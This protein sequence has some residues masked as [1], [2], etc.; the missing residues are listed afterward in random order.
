[1]SNVG[2]VVYRVEE[3][4]LGAGGKQGHVVAPVGLRMKLTGS[5]VLLVKAL[6]ERVERDA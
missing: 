6:E 1:M 3:V 2:V 5:D 4:G